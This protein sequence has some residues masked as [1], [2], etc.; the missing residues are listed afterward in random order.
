VPIFVEEAC[1]RIADELLA[2]GEPGAGTELPTGLKDELKA[3]A[4]KPSSP[5]PAALKASIKW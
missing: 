5:I 1:A 3:A 2:L 4:R